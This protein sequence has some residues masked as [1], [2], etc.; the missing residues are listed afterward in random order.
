MFS[1]KPPAGARTERTLVGIK[2][3]RNDVNERGEDEV[4]VTSELAQTVIQ[5]YTAKEEEMLGKHG[6]GENGGGEGRGV[7]PERPSPLS[8]P[9]LP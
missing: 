4:T 8:T 7:D 3:P 5:S 9:S 6:G 2:I 1:T